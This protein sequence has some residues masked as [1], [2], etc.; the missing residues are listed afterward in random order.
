MTEEKTKQKTE[1]KQ[2]EIEKPIDK[3]KP[4][5]SQSK[6]IQYNYNSSSQSTNSQISDNNLQA[7]N[8]SITPSQNPS[9][10]KKPEQSQPISQQSKPAISKT[11]QTSDINKQASQ[12]TK[13]Q[14]SQTTSPHQNKSQSPQTSDNKSST[15]KDTKPKKGLKEP[16]TSASHPKKEEAVAYGRN[17]HASKKH[18]IYIS[19]FIKNKSI[20]K[21]IQDLQLVIEKR[22]AI[23][24]K[25]EIPHRKGMMSGRYPVKASKQIIN[26]LKAL[27][28][29][30]IINGLDLQKTKIS[31]ASAN[32]SSRPLR[33]NSRSFKRTNIILKAKEAN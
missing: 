3:Q 24:F 10:N 14:P 21:A 25:G 7:K 11:I 33:S 29:N 19:S 30:S 13:P 26:I 28:G 9:N 17:L 22:K 6:K 8:V 27:K 5:A 31:I 20:D 23:P 4:A 16:K 32:W 18:C 15:I 2:E 12:P 1:N